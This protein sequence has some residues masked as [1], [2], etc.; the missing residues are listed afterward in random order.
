[1]GTGKIRT[2]DALLED[3]VATAELT[4][5]P[6]S[7]ATLRCV[8]E[9]FEDGFMN[10]SVQMRTTTKPVGRRDLCF[11]YLDL[12]SGVNP[13][14][15]AERTGLLTS[16]GHP[17]FGW[18]HRVRERFPALG[19]GADFEACRGLVKV[20]YFI[21]GAYDPRALLELPHMPPSFRPSL[22]LLREL[23][24]DAMTIL[25]VDYAQGSI[26]LYFRPSHP[27][28]RSGELLARACERLGFE[29][30][31]AAAQAHAGRAGC[32][33]FTYGWDAPEIE[34]ICFYVAGFSRDEV[35]DHHPHLR[36][37]ARQAPALV[38]DPRFIVGWSHGR[39]GSYLKIE[40][41]YTGD[42]SGV[43]QVAMSVARV[44][45]PAAAPRPAADVRATAM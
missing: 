25:A 1:M 44:P 10:T 21:G 43:F 6:Y 34:R 45:L 22:P 4:G 42:V 3:L 37:F 24:L 29:A 27:S 18:L 38:D 23:H 2:I 14:D 36:A 17:L 20:W 13:L 40:D 26:N 31:S 5:A 19:Y 7:E 33:A 32:I 8:L 11:R 39:R 35:P 15:V 41:D 9:I 30:P 16:T 12:V 28:H